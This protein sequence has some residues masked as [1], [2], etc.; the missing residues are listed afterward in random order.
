MHEPQPINDPSELLHHIRRLS[1]EAEWGENEL[2]EALREGGVDPHHLVSRVMADIHRYFRDDDSD[3]RVSADRTAPAR[4]F[5]IALRDST[6]LPSST[7]AEALEVP[8]PFLSMVTRHPN[9]VPMRWR[10]ELAR[11]AEQRLEIDSEAVLQ[12]FTSPFQFDRAAFRGTPYTA[13]TVQ[14]Y[15]D[16]LERSDMTPEMRQFWQNLAGEA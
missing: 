5:L 7:I 15:E 12:S 11:R 14:H 6:R 13:D 2:D 3:G 9:A 10:Q 4:P 16:I 8:V 1:C